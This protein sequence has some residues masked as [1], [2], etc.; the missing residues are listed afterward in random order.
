M[1][2]MTIGGLLIGLGSVWFVMS[3]GHVAHLLLNPFAAILVFGGTIGSTFISYPWKTIKQA[4]HVLLMV[5]FPRRQYTAKKAIDILTDLCEK[6]KK[7]GLDSLQEEMENI[8]DKFL[9]N[10]IKLLV[11]RIDPWVARENLEKEITFTRKR[12]RQISGMFRTMG[13]YA[14]VFGLLGTLIGV[15]QVLKNLTSPEAMGESM[16][17]AVTTTFYGIF[18]ANFIFTPI[19]EKLESYSD[20]E[21]LIKEVMIEGVLSIQQGDIPIILQ[22]KLQSFLAYRTREQEEKQ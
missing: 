1:D 9:L 2:L 18:G 6:A 5:L 15:V 8:D 17:I 11:D 22:K 7:N 4:P 3:A 12:H 21:L 20:E 16:A 10:G 13:T 19:A 14:P